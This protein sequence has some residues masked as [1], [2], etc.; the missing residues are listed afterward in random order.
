M[1]SVT[2]FKCNQPGHYGTQCPATDLGKARAVNNIMV[3]FQQVTTRSK[4]QSTQWQIQDAVKQAAK[5]WIENANKT[6]VERMHTEMQDITIGAPQS[7]QPSNSAENDQLWDS[8]T[9]S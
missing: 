6:N 1:A 5:E 3:G 9:S 7:T 2:C 8:L 4:T